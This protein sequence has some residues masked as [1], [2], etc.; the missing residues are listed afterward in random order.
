MMSRCWKLLALLLTFC[1]WFLVGSSQPVQAA[2]GEVLGI[3]I[4]STA[5]LPAASTLLKNPDKPESWHYVT[6]PVTLND[7]Q[8]QQEWQ[9][10]FNQARQ[11]QII[12]LVRLA[13]KVEGDTW[14]VP[15]RHDITQLISFL[16]NLT[17]PTEERYIIILNETNH[18]KEFG[19]RISPEEYA[20]IL[21]FASQWA[22]SEHKNY[23]ILPGAMDLAAPNGPVTMEAF[24]YLNRMVA[25]DPEIFNHIDYLNSHA[26][27][28]P[29]FSSAPQRKGQNTLEGFKYEL[30]YLKEKTGKD[31]QVFITE[32]GWVENRATSRWLSNY[33][34]YALQHIW[35]DARV[36]AVT[37]FIL[38]G[39][40]G[41]FAGFSFLDETG[42]PTNQYLAY[43]RL[44][45]L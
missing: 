5:E 7:L 43:Q 36:K 34:Q 3:H 30:A 16:S 14:V 13:T 12:P 1:W 22:R 11:Q 2:E 45:Q 4:L 17:W 32:T 23:V 39:S 9:N 28:N 21:R 41:P 31:F 42:R 33:Y 40:P 26:Y 24:T 35:S 20:D 18:A 25:F 19:G 10:F 8:K 29:G 15:S 27:P 6:I 37:P 38:Q 44:L